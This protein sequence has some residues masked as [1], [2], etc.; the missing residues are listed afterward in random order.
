MDNVLGNL[1]DEAL[2]RALN[3]LSALISSYDKMKLEEENFARFALLM[4]KARRLLQALQSQ[5]SPSASP[6]NIANLLKRMDAEV[7]KARRALDSYNS[8]NWFLRL[9]IFNSVLSKLE[10]S[11]T[12]ISKIL[13]FLP[14]NN[15]TMALNINASL[16][17]L[18]N[19]G[20]DFESAKS[21][22]D[23]DAI[24]LGID[25]LSAENCGKSGSGSET[26]SPSPGTSF[27]DG[28]I[29][30][31]PFFYCPLTCDLMVDPV[32]G[33]CGHCFERRALEA[34]FQEG[35]RF[36]TIC[37][38]PL[39]STEKLELVSNTNLRSIIEEWKAKEKLRRA[40]ARIATNNLESINE[41]LAELLALMSETPS[42]ISAAKESSVRLVSNLA[43]LLKDNAA[44]N[45]ALL[46]CLLLIASYSDDNKENIGKRGVIKCLV[47]LAR[48]EPVAVDLL[49]ELSKHKEVAYKIGETKD[50][51]STL[52]SIFDNQENLAEK[53]LS[54]LENV[55]NNVDFMVS[56]IQS[57]YFGPFL[58]QFCEVGDEDFYPV[59]EKL[60]QIRLTRTAARNLEN[61]QFTC[62][63][64]EM[65]RGSPPSSKSSFLQ[66]IHRL[67]EFSGLRN[68][69]LSDQHLTQV[70]LDLI[71]DS[72]PEEKKNRE[73]ALEILIFLIKIS[74][75]I[76]LDQLPGLLELSS[77][78]SIQ[79]FINQIR[80]LD[81]V[82]QVS[83]LQL[84]L[85]LIKKSDAARNLIQSSD[86][87]IIYILSLLKGSPEDK[88]G[89]LALKLIYYITA[90]HSIGIALPPSP[91]KEAI[92]QYIT[93]IY[94]SSSIEEDGR[95]A[96]AGIIAHLPPL[97]QS[98]SITLRAINDVIFLASNS[99][100]LL[101][102]AL[103]V[104]L[105]C[106]EQ[107]N[108]EVLLNAYELHPAL[109]QLLSAGSPPAKRRAAMILTHLSRHAAISKSLKAR[110]RHSFD[111]LLFVKEC[112]VHGSSCFEQHALCLIKV[113]AVRPLVEVVSSAEPA[114][115]EAALM[116]LGTL[117]DAGCDTKASAAAIAGSGGAARILEVLGK[118]QIAVDGKALDLLEKLWEHG[119]ITK[120]ECAKLTGKLLHLLVRE[121]VKELRSKATEL[122][123]KLK[124]P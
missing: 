88:I 81:P 118:G 30:P 77:C 105:W 63:L 32:S 46:R 34:S 115:T 55:S 35:N 44:D 45:K 4:E 26:A 17:N 2:T 52:I 65:L 97:H 21:A 40:A 113:G 25:K 48:V 12:E 119:N 98:S 8:A 84:V 36:C 82:D 9:L 93:S 41:V 120:E 57:G 71:A 43:R 33:S 28:D 14:L 86:N 31:S 92:M 101:E 80:I 66:C 87:L 42:C 59:V 112:S 122:L 100:E 49:L 108:S 19:V 99:N 20:S 70:L 111:K 76:E 62:R 124:I 3:A 38:A 85:L 72:V 27:D 91:D 75:S 60:S 110:L 68:L 73:A 39:T 69:F 29:K 121:E 7:T 56:L 5:N 1:R 107:P 51:I 102:N 103:G 109:I 114:A 6:L 67:I 10:K 116:A 64:T 123:A 94:T 53:A 95:S 61:K 24:I 79:F 104:L 37:N 23:P 90:D 54:V 50:A 58:D 13:E 16:E 96:A 89:L 106:I 22:V 18:L 78:N 11:S 83:L 117:F 74:Q 15:I 47:M